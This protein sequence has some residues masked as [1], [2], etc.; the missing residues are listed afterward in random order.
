VSFTFT[1][2]E[3][4]RRQH[5]ELMRKRSRAYGKPGYEDLCKQEKE[6]IDAAILLYANPRVPGC[7]SCEEYSIFGGP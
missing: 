1:D 4:A 3:D 2:R 7:R 5:S 6:L